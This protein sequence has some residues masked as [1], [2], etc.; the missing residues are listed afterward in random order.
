M[1]LAEKNEKKEKKEKEEQVD[2]LQDYIDLLGENDTL[3]E[4]FLALEKDN[5]RLG[6]DYSDAVSEITKLQ[7][8]LTELRVQLDSSKREITRLT[9]KW[10]DWFSFK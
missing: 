7:L 8:K 1:S 10:K 3:T 6:Q 5:V 9:P 4:R 2:V